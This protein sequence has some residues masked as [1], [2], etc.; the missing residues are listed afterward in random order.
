MMPVSA[1]VSVNPGKNAPEG[2]MSTPSRSPTAPQTP[3][4]T[5][6]KA[7]PAI[8]TGIIPK[9]IRRNCVLMETNRV[10]IMS[11]A[12]RSARHVRMVTFRTLFEVMKKL[13]SLEKRKTKKPARKAC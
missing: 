12:M 2:K 5:G 9:P 13:L 8:A 10:R 1:A 11:S 4:H 6:P 3:P 7:A